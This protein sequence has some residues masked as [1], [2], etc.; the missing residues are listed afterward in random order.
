MNTGLFG[1]S[2]NFVPLADATA[3]EDEVVV[4]HGKDKVKDSPQ[5]GEGQELSRED[6]AELYRYYGIDY[7]RDGSDSMARR[8]SGLG[9]RSGRESD[10]SSRPRLDAMD[11]DDHGTAQPVEAF[12]RTLSTSRTRWFATSTPSTS[13]TC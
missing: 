2:S 6:E 12:A 8:P 3:R 1:T 5:L 9:A 11:G 10:S 13:C 7:D 4:A